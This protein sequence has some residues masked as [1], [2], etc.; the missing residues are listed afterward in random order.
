[1]SGRT[2]GLVLILFLVQFCCISTGLAQNGPMLSIGP[3]VR[4]EPVANYAAYPHADLRVDVPLIL[5]PVHVTTPLGTSVTDLRQENFR[6]FEDGVEQPLTSF[7]KEDAPLSIGMVFDSSGSMHTKIHKSSEAASV[8]FKIANPEDEFFLVEFNDRPKLSVP[9]TRD[10]DEVY[11]RIARIRAAGRTSL[12]DAIHMALA[13]MKH[14]H[15]LRKAIIIFSDGGDN[16]SRFTEREVKEAML[17]SDVQ[18]YAMGIFEMT[19]SHKLS[20]EELDGPR[21]LTEL[22]E[23]TGGKHFPVDH[24]DDLPK[25]CDRIGNELRNQ[26]LL[27]YIPSNAARDGR[28]RKIKVT[29]SNTASRP[30]LKPFYRQGYYAPLQ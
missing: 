13:Q 7:A 22:A 4:S 2:A 18:V 10:S 3:G 1:M 25:V 17:E 19:D 16:R 5:I 21:L 23:E 20:R 29:L 27:G 26:Y 12:L 15:N 9:F 11:N 28:Y 6:V 8:F 30:Q 14:A 24:L